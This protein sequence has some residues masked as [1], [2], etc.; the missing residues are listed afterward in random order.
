MTNADPSLFSTTAAATA[1][2]LGFDE[3]LAKHR[4]ES[5][6]NDDQGGVQAIS[7]AD[8]LARIASFERR[9]QQEAQR[10]RRMMRR[11]SETT[12]TTT[13]TDQVEFTQWQP[14]KNLDEDQ[15]RTDTFEQWIPPASYDQ[16]IPPPSPVES[17]FSDAT[18]AEVDYFL[19]P[20]SD[21]DAEEDEWASNGITLPH[22]VYDPRLGYSLF[23]HEEHALDDDDGLPMDDDETLAVYPPFH[24]LYPMHSMAY[25]LDSQRPPANILA[26][27]DELGTYIP[28]SL[29]AALHNVPCHP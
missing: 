15:P 26:G 12:T 25:T 14:P 28:Y 3:Q 20:S 18:D 2:D 13:T 17:T 23:D 10:A 22:L 1:V 29:F 8:F 5:A 16:W 27:D 9:E 24:D 4:L 11:W 7:E 21:I 19:D 6:N